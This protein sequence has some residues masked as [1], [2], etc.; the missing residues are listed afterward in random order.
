MGNFQISNPNTNNQR[1]FKKTLGVKYFQNVPSPFIRGVKKKVTLHFYYIEFNYHAEPRNHSSNSIIRAL[2]LCKD[3]PSESRVELFPLPQHIPYLAI[4]LRQITVTSRVEM[5][6]RTS[7]VHCCVLLWLW[8]SVT[9]CGACACW[10]WC[11]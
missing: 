10:W 2:F 11:A 5:V 9:C 8:W 1:A 6:V 7:S 4:I 3:L